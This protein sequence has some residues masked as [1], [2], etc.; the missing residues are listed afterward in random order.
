MGDH[1]RVTNLASGWGDLESRLAVPPSSSLTGGP[2]AR[3]LCA[4]TSPSV[5]WGDSEPRRV[6][7][8]KCVPCAGHRA[9]GPHDYQPSSLH[10]CDTPEVLAKIYQTLLPRHPTASRRFPPFYEGERLFH[11][12]M[13]WGRSHLHNFKSHTLCSTSCLVSYNLQP[14]LPEIHFR[15]V[16]S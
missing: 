1:H 6:A 2:A 4:S 13:G 7:Q 11:S 3:S 8:W 12:G 5:E 16:P 15:R 9:H 14:Y 10:H